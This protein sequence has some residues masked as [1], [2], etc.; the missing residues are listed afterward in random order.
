MNMIMLSGTP[1]S[2]TEGVPTIE[3]IALGLSRTFRFGGQTALPF[4]VLDHSLMMTRYLPHI[5]K[6][7]EITNTMHGLG[8]FH[9]WHECLTGDIPRPFKTPDMKTLQ[10]ELDSRFYNS[11]HLHPTRADFA[12]LKVL[13][14]NLITVE[15]SC[16]NF[17][18]FVEWGQMGIR[19]DTFLELRGDVMEL[20][21]RPMQDK[22]TEYLGIASDII[23]VLKLDANEAAGA[24]R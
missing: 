8:F 24:T 12:M 6:D 10:E 9:D 18:A 2:L 13:D 14:D 1:V 17:G 20:V 15:A 22:I 23:E 16:L 7:H 4:T 3:D 11:I 21:K 19:R 5:G